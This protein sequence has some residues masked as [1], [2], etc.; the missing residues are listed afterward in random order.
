MERGVVV[1]TNVDPPS[2][3]TGTEAAEVDVTLKSLDKPVVAPDASA[4]V[5]V[6]VITRSVREGLIFR[7]DI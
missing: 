3:E 2:V 1:N 5:I 6:H 4:T 7:Q